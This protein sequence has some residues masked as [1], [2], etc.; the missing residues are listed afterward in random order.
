MCGHQP[1]LTTV[2]G[3]PDSVRAP[4]NLD[5]ALIARSIYQNILTLTVTSVYTVVNKSFLPQKMRG[6]GFE[7][8]CL[9]AIGPQPIVSAS[10]TIPAS[11]AIEI[12]R[13]APQEGETSFPLLAFVRKGALL[14]HSLFSP[15]LH[16]TLSLKECARSTDRPCGPGAASTPLS[17]LPSSL[18]LP[19]SRVSLRKS[20][21]GSFGR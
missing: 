12:R 20:R 3:H 17:L 14:A 13:L 6:G 21:H 2:R 8:P 4:R 18:F 19:D 9:A 1:F 7:P 15:F 11:L 5:D 10:F 16:L